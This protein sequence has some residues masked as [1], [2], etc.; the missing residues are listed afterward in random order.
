MATTN[1]PKKPYVPSPAPRMTHRL[2]STE[3]AMAEARDNVDGIDL[4]VKDPVYLMSNG[5]KFYERD[6]Y[7]PP[8]VPADPDLLP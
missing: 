7:E 4:V 1:K 6:P 3:V 8:D 5:R 2:W